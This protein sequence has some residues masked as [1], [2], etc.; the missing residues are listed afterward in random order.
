MEP[1]PMRQPLALNWSAELLDAAMRFLAPATAV[2]S[3]TIV[4]GEMSS[5]VIL[6][7]HRRHRIGWLCCAI[8]L[9]Q[10]GDGLS[11]QY[12]RYA[13]AG[14]P[15]GRAGVVASWLAAWMWVPAIGLLLTSLVL[16]FPAGRLPSRRWRPVAWT[17]AESMAALMVL[18]A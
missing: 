17:A 8:G 6:A 3:L 18:F 14:H 13:L 11:S 4:A 12:A 10:A 16:L 7:H 15:G 5:V 9:A 2:S 1:A